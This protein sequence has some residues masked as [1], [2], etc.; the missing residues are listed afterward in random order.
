M[1]IATGKGIK[2]AKI[3]DSE[4]SGEVIISKIETLPLKEGYDE[5]LLVYVM[6]EDNTVEKF[7]VG[8]K[9]HTDLKT[10]SAFMTEVKFNAESKF[11]ANAKYSFVNIGA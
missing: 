8:K 5:N 7:V 10:G 6:N 4:L 2:S 9:K 11:G 1:S 3:I